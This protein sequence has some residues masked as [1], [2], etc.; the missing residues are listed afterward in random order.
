MSLDSPG[1]PQ[2]GGVPSPL[3]GK[4]DFRRAFHGLSM[5]PLFG[6]ITNDNDDDDE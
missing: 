3:L 6:C 2:A 5:S 1:G 4:R